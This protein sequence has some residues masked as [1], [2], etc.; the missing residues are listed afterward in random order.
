MF[1]KRHVQQKVKTLLRMEFTWFNMLSLSGRPHLSGDARCQHGQ[2][3]AS[4]LDDKKMA[5]NEWVGCAE[6]HSWFRCY[7]I[8]VWCSSFWWHN[9]MEV[10]T[11]R[12]PKWW[13]RSIGLTIQWLPPWTQK[14][15]PK[16]QP[17]PLSRLF[18]RLHCLQI[19]FCPIKATQQLVKNWRL[20]IAKAQK[21]VHFLLRSLGFCGSEQMLP[22]WTSERMF[23]GEFW[24]NMALS[25]FRLILK[26]MFGAQTNRR[27][28]PLDP[29]YV[30]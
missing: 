27:L 17:F 24:E 21:T 29:R 9:V 25:T 13:W 18:L 30:G 1:S 3:A 23:C 20:Q 10:L 6:F 5:A 26:S 22:L 2:M 19:Y 28:R 11:W 4:D 14:H 15:S 12:M 16:I 7:E 8:V